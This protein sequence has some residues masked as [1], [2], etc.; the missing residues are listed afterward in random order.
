LT[1][2][3]KAKTFKAKTFE[4]KAEAGIFWRNNTSM[5]I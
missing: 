3:A 1:R 4:D 2:K 5:V